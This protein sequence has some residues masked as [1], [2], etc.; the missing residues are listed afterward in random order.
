MKKEEISLLSWNI[1]T[2]CNGI[3]QSYP[4]EAVTDFVFSN[5]IMWHDGLTALDIFC[6][7]EI[8]TKKLNGGT[9]TPLSCLEDF[10]N[11]YD[12]NFWV[13]PA[14]GLEYSLMTVIRK[15]SDIKLLSY[16]NIGE[17]RFGPF[18]QRLELEVNE[19]TVLLYNTH[20][21]ANNESDEGR[22]EWRS[23]QISMINN[24]FDRVPEVKNA[25]VAGDL[26]IEP[27]N[28][29]KQWSAFKQILC[30]NTPYKE[31]IG[32]NVKSGK[33]W[34]WSPKKKYDYIGWIGQKEEW[35]EHEVIKVG[36]SGGCGSLRHF[37]VL[38]FIGF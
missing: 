35:F 3:R 36:H 27:K 26:N 18:V 23:R 16:H 28:L 29:Q 4:A 8:P 11:K 1:G 5:N 17:S 12:R 32:E 20:L 37:P 10:T 25:V 15:Q 2:C 31:S 38:A 9:G 34:K 7:Q 33:Q 22:D 6:F 30:D 14:F 19:K 24:D 13:I 21:A